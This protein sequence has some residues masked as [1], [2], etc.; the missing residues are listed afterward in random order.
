MTIETGGPYLQAALFC[1][2]VLEDKSGV[3]SLIRIIDRITITASGLQAP[4]EMPAVALNLAIILKA[5]SLRSKYKLHVKPIAPNGKELA[6]VSTSI[7]LEGEDRGVN[8]ILDVNL[9]VQEEGLYWFEIFFEEMLLTRIP[10][11]IVYQR[12]STPSRL[13]GM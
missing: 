4:E 11:R 10:L 3:L 9:P 6:T 13:P 8:I 5:G 12:L 7:L 1:E 2:K